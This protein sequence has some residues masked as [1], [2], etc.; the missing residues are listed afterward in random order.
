MGG[1]WTELRQGR[2]RKRQFK[3]EGKG[4]NE[5]EKGDSPQRK[6]ARDSL[7]YIRINRSDGAPVISSYL[8]P[9]TRFWY[10]QFVREMHYECESHVR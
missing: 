8:L 6:A 9:L 1:K 2:V 7:L 10:F 5:I 3:K 4:H